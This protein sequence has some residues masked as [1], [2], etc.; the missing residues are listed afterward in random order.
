VQM[1]LGGHPALTRHPDL[2]PLYR[3]AVDKLE[4]LYQAA[5]RMDKP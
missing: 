1:A 5:G 4:D 3:E 2:M